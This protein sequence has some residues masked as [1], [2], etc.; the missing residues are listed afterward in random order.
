[1][2]RS[3]WTSCTRHFS[4]MSHHMNCFSSHR[5]CDLEWPSFEVNFKA[6]L[7]SPWDQTFE[8]SACQNEVFNDWFDFCIWKSILSVQMTYGHH[9]Y[10]G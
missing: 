10:S 8:N 2:V 9:F 4:G 5:F 6:K 1:L 3:G 7:V